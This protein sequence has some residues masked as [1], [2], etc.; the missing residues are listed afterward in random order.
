[1]ELVES[2]ARPRA[3]PQTNIARV[4]RSSHA[5]VG[6]V[7][8]EGAVFAAGPKTQSTSV[9]RGSVGTDGRFSTGP[10]GSYTWAGSGTGGL[11]GAR[12]AGVGGSK[13]VPVLGWRGLGG[14]PCIDDA[15]GRS[16]NNS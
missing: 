3:G 9:E 5:P 2:R 15:I 12:F 16:R 13:T 4:E 8:Q 11:V 10:P 14:G 7:V 6:S 1:M